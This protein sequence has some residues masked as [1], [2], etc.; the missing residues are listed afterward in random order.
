V[1]VKKCTVT[2]QK[3]KQVYFNI[4][5]QTAMTRSA[6]LTIRQE[7]LDPDMFYVK[8]RAVTAGVPNNNGDY[9]SVDVLK[10]S[11]KTFEGRGVF[12]NH[13][14]D[15][16]EAARGKI[17]SAD[18]IEQD[19]NDVHVVLALAIDQKAFP[20][21]ANAIKKGYVTDVSMGATVAFSLCSICG[22]K[23]TNE[24]EYCHH[25]KY[26]KGSSF[27]GKP[28]YEDN[29]GVNF[30]EISAVTNG[31]DTTAKVI[32][33]IDPHDLL[34]KM[35]VQGSNVVELEAYE[36]QPGLQKA[37]GFGEGF[38]VQKVSNAYEQLYLRVKAA[39][40]KGQ[41][42]D[43]ISTQL[44]ADSVDELTIFALHDKLKSE[45]LG[46]KEA[47]QIRFHNMDGSLLNQ[48][49]NSEPAKPYNPNLRTDFKGFNK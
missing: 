9:F 27:Q 11:Y 35:E 22:N 36:N 10:E 46:V 13:E 38:K 25:I 14:S 1:L 5:G 42:W 45:V 33:E 29:K 8:V 7:D 41:D 32:A 28:V 2:T 49:L 48:L 40:E 47:E 15:N 20:Q 12:V 18:L 19:P 37:A 16:V 21:L 24:S 6:A 23:A 44:K 34:Q 31:A 26:F 43:E 17:L 4:L 39:F 3:H 30:F